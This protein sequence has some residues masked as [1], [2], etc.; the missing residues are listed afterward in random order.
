[1]RFTPNA[2]VVAGLIAIAGALPVRAQT[3][4][5]PPQAAPTTAASA[6]MPMDCAKRASRPHDHGMERGA[7]P[8]VP[9]PCLPGRAASAVKAKKRV[10]PRAAG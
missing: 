2:I 5:P 8:T 4:P 9:N 10:G 7:G 6:A 1:M 3:Q